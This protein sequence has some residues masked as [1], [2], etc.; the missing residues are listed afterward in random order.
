[1]KPNPVGWFEIYVQDVARARRFYETVL[2]TT[3]SRLE[4]DGLEIGAV[5]AVELLGDR[6]QHGDGGRGLEITERDGDFATDSGSLVLSQRLTE[7]EDI[8]VGRAQGA[9]S[10][11]SLLRF[12]G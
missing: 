7:G 3:L 5:L 6:D 4:A 10:R 9:E 11:E 1:M 8:A 12:L 2:G